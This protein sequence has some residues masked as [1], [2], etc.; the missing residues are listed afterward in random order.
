LKAEENIKGTEWKEI[1]T[2]VIK[3]YCNIDEA[4]FRARLN[5]MILDGPKGHNYYKLILHM[6]W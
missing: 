1:K 5:A 6:T 4:A 2:T 3:Q